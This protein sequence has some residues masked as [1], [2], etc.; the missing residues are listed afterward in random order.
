MTEVLRAQMGR[1]LRPIAGSALVQAGLVAVA[2]WQGSSLAFYVILGLALSAGAWVSI[3]RLWGDQFLGRAD[4]AAHLRFALSASR[5]LASGQ[6]FLALLNDAPVGFQPFFLYY[7]MLPAYLAGVLKLVLGL[8]AYEAVLLT[9]ALSFVGAGIGVA[10]VCRYLRCGVV[11]AALAAWAY[12]FSPYAFDNLYARGALPEFSANALLP[13]ALWA[14]LRCYSSRGRHGL[15]LAALLI[16][17]LM[18]THKIQ[19]PWFLLAFGSLVVLTGLLPGG[20]C[21]RRFGRIVARAL[22]AA[23]SVALGLAISAAYWLEAYQVVP[24]LLLAQFLSTAYESLTQ[25]LR[26]IWPLYQE[27]PGASGTT[28]S[29][30]LGAPA[31]LGMFM[32]CVSFRR[33]LPLAIGLVAL[34]SALLAAAGPTVWRLMPSFLASVQFPYRLLAQATLFGLLGLALALHRLVRHVASRR[35]RFVLWA[36]SAT[37]VLLTSIAFVHPL[38]DGPYPPAT[39]FEDETR[40]PTILPIE[41]VLFPDDLV[42]SLTAGQGS[43]FDANFQAVDRQLSERF[44]DDEPSLTGTV[45][46][47]HRSSVEIA[48]NQARTIIPASRP[49]LYVLPVQFSPYTWVSDTNDSDQSSAILPA[50]NVD[51]KTAVSLEPGSHRLLLVRGMTPLALPISIAGFVL[52]GM[53]ILLGR[54]RFFVGLRW[55]RR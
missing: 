41:Y 3:G 33:R 8:S 16:A 6:R 54:C 4:L 25:G 14:L 9:F 45:I 34:A 40:T 47:V 1:A 30:Q 2:R 22:P 42:A 20:S 55:C 52:F 18:V 26:I 32:S 49:G 10:L 19:L 37:M 23:G 44:Y 7:S 28:L 38:P 51:G 39:L 53:L 27:A 5:E 31:V 11:P 21:S 43:S 29:L 35:A 17:A 13:I 36:G 24:H 15:A 12:A 50:Q 46:L 48:G